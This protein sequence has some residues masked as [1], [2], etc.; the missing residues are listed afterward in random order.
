MTWIATQRFIDGDPLTAAQLN[1]FVMDNLD[2]S[3]AGIARNKGRYIVTSGYRQLAERQ[4]VRAYAS[5]TVTATND[6]P[7][8]PDEEDDLGPSVTFEHGG[9]FLCYYSCR[10]Q[11]VTTDGFMNYAPVPDPTPEGLSVYSYAVRSTK[12]TYERMGSHM[13]FTGLE[14]GMNTVTMKYGRNSGNGATGN[15]AQRRLSVLPL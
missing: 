5:G 14:P 4:W 2:A 1:T 3:C 7:S 13:L 11:R 6:W 8:D 12:S 10:I 9:S 15:Y